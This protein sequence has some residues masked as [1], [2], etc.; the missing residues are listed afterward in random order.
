[1][2]GDSDTSAAL[3]V[4]LAC[5]VRG[6]GEPLARDGQRVVCPRRHTFD[7]AR[8]GYFNL[9]QPQ[10]R[11]SHAPGDTSDAVAARAA[12]IAAGIGRSILTAVASRAA[13]FL[14]ATGVVVDLGSGAGDL[15]G[16]LAEIRAIAGV[17]IDISTAA[18]DRAARRFPAVTWV[19]ANADRRLPLLDRSVDVVLSV[20]GRRSPEECAR[21]L[22]ADGRLLIAVPAPDD[23]IE[24]REQ[25]QGEGVQRE[26][27]DAVISEHH[28][29]FTLAERTEIRERHDLERRELVNLLKGTYRG[30]RHGVAGRVE[31][32]EKM[33]V[34]LASDVL[35]FRL[36]PST[37][38]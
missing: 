25:V 14:P 26:R 11:R 37:D 12:S 8:S 2:A 38:T 6:C 24:L 16:G 22:K 20:H 30:A 34:T 27:A 32:L 31:Q 29:A 7:M 5:T 4:P 33:R 3:A 18:A 23:L 9:L 21:V 1:M 17:G 13:S 35:M 19:V 15:L 36:E 28:G 10:D